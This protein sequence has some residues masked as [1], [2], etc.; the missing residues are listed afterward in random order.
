MEKSSIDGVIVENWQENKWEL[1]RLS[2]L[3]ETSVI[4]SPT[5]VGK[6]EMLEVAQ[7]L[8]AVR[9]ESEMLMKIGRKT[10]SGSIPLSAKE[11]SQPAWPSPRKSKKAN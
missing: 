9:K 1:A 6:T 7:N 11:Q 3:P 2:G 5:K 8:A 4:L 10:N